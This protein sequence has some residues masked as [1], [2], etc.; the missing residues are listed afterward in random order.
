MSKKKSTLNNLKILLILGRINGNWGQWGSWS[1]CS[2]TCGT[3]SKSRRRS[4]NNPAPAYGGSSCPGVSY[5]STSCSLQ[6]KCS[7]I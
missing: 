3:G 7:F 2:K 1:S 5:A 4:C 6:S